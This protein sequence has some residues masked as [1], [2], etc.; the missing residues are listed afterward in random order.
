ML[1]A[2]HGEQAAYVLKQ[3]AKERF[4]TIHFPGNYLPIKHIT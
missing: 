1:K 3:T 4:V 2:I